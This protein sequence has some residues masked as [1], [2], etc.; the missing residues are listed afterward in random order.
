[1]EIS[2][3]Q[4]C[5][6]TGSQQGLDIVAKSFINPGDTVLV[7]RPGYLGAIQCFSLYEPVFESV[8]LQHDGPDLNA[9]SKIIAER[10]VKLFYAVPTFQNPSGLTYSLEKRKAVADLLRG[11]DV[12]LLEDNPYGELRFSGQDV[13]PMAQN[14]L[15][16]NALLMGSFSKIVAPGLRLGWVVAPE[17][18]YDKLILAKQAADLHTSTLNQR[19]V[20]R[21]L[22]DNDL[23][24][25]L[26]LIKDNYGENCRAM[27]KAMEEHFPPEVTFTRPEGGMF[28]WASLP[29]GYDAMDLFNLAIEKNVAFVPGRSFYCD[30]TGENCLR[31]NFS[32]SS[33]KNIREGIERIGSCIRQ[34]LDKQAENK[35]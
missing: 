19:I 3:D 32:N 12:I 10:D 5:I 14:F 25:H 24:K 35:P 29:E 2:P 1:M 33:L 27:I 9:L 23:S 21:F 6:T 16:S 13:P 18:F 17:E 11:K 20:H 31:I 30:G 7:E 26:E 4:I 22:V 34:L 8:E 28:V 15:H